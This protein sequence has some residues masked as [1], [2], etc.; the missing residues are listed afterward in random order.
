MRRSQSKNNIKKDSRGFVVV[1]SFGA[2]RVRLNL[3]EKADF[4]VESAVYFVNRVA[5]QGRNSHKLPL[6]NEVKNNLGKDMSFDPNDLESEL[7]SLDGVTICDENEYIDT[8]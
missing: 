6:R 7:E 1:V 3:L 2:L 4:G 8:G 5:R